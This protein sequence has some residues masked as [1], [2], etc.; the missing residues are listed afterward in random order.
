VALLV[1]GTAGAG[2]HDAQAGYGDVDAQGFPSW[3]ERN[4]HIWTNVVRVAPEDFEEEYNLGGC[5]FDDFEASEQ[6]PKDPLYYDRNLNIASRAHCDDM[7]SNNWF[8]HDSS[9]G[10]AWD[11]RI[12]QYYSESSYIGENIAYGYGGGYNTIMLGWMCSSGHR[13][14]I[15]LA[16]YNELGTGEVSDYHT[17]DFAAGSV[18]TDG[19]VAMGSHYP[20]SPSATV[21]FYLDWQDS[22]AP[23]SIQ[24]VLDGEGL[25]LELAWGEDTLGVFTLTESVSDVECSE[26]FFRW[27]TAAGESGTFPGDGSYQY[28]PDCDNDLMWVDQQL[29]PYDEDQSDR[30]IQDLLLADI[31][32]VGCAT[33]RGTRSAHALGLVLLALGLRRRRR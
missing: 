7:Y 4:D 5:S 11:V 10:T 26:Y 8:D 31:E 18:D 16:D 9:D 20:E 17:Q 15:M 21:A 28:G 32:L 22:D 1:L 23:A 19:P 29:E 33:T 30:D 27:T 6:T 13:S 2:T 3:D 24:V 12:G 25:D 14:N